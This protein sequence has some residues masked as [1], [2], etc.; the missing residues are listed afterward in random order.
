MSGAAATNADGVHLGHFFG[1]SEQCG[2]RSEGPAHVILIEPRGD[3]SNAGIG[4][5]HAD[6]DDAGIEELHFVDA[7]HLYADFHARQKLGA[8]AH[9]TGFQAAIVARDDVVGREAIVDEGFE[10]LHALPGDE[11][12]PQ[13][14]DQ[15]FRFSREHASSDDLDPAA[16]ITVQWT[17]RDVVSSQDNKVR[18][19]WFAVI[20]D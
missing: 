10:H 6:I 15:L 9:R 3:D 19:S 18:G 12:A 4:E 14:P 11:C 2:H 16:F 13:A 1:D 17:L 5:L 7:N 20:I 8:A